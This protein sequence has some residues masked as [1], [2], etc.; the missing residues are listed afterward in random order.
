MSE[1]LLFFFSLCALFN[2]DSFFPVVLYIPFLQGLLMSENILFF[3]FYVHYLTVIR[4][5]PVVLYIPFFTSVNIILSSFIPV[6][7][8]DSATPISQ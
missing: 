3:P 5:F 8:W 4:F 1:N 6:F 2:C 7:F